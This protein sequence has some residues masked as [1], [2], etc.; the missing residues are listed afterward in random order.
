MDSSDNEEKTS[1]VPCLQ[2]SIMVPSEAKTTHYFHY[3]WKLD[4]ALKLP[5]LA[6]FYYEVKKVLISNLSEF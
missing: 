4:A 1:R 5:Y 6:D 3:V 2:V